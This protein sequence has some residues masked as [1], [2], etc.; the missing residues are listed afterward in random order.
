[1]LQN[2]LQIDIDN[3]HL[4]VPGS[5]PGTGWPIHGSWV[6]DDSQYRY[7]TMVTYQVDNGLSIGGVI[8]IDIDKVIDI[9]ELGLC[10]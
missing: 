1:M 6:K 4:R 3:G 8:D 10:T 9:V 5:N 7:Q 2:A